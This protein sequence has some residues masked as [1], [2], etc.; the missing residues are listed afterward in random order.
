MWFNGFITVIDMALAG[1]DRSPLFQR[2]RD[3]LVLGAFREDVWFVPG[4]EFVLQSAS[5]THFRRGGLP[6]GFIPYL[7]P[8]AAQRAGRFLERAVREFA[9]GRDASAF[10]QLGRAAHPLIDM[11]CP[12][13]AQGV[14]HAA[15]PFEWCVEALGDELR[16]LA[17]P[18]T[19]LPSVESVVE[20]LA[21]LGQ[22]FAADKTTS[23]WGRVL[24]RLGRRQPVRAALAR[25][26]AKVLIPLA[27]GHTAALFRLFLRK[28]QAREAADASALAQTLRHLEMSPAGLR[29]WLGQLERFCEAHG[30][31]RHYRELLNLIARCRAQLDDDG[32]WCAPS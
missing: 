28:T 21:R 8:G 19:D 25:E 26:Q 13:H 9:A 31:G 32:A 30:G 15:D 4:V 2:H 6:G 10:V 12:V 27:A 16:T 3:A 7:W 17:V 18:R 20:S 24:R 23:P 1:M 29:A 14:A 22:G 5:L 11:A